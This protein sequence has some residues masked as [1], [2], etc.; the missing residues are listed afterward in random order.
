M[1]TCIPTGLGRIFPQ[2]SQ[3]K[4][5]FRIS[6]KQL[7]RSCP[8]KLEKVITS[9][10]RLLLIYVH[11]LN[12]QWYDVWISFSCVS[13]KPKFSNSVMFIWF[14]KWNRRIR[15]KYGGQ[16][17]TFAITMH[18]LGPWNRKHS[19]FQFFFHWFYKIKFMQLYSR[20][21]QDYMTELRGIIFV[22]R[23][24]E[25]R[26]NNIIGTPVY[27][28]QVV[29]RRRKIWIILIY[30]KYKTTLFIFLFLFHITEFM[31]FI[32]TTLFQWYQVHCIKQLLTR[33]ILWSYKETDACKLHCNS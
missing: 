9:V 29:R 33:T 16:K 20:F 19:R 23:P 31:N 1:D 25:S 24:V 3:S 8:P 32:L 27:I 30:K 22:I 5:Q 17:E 4:W 13:L 18:G 12:A 10:F 26:N 28:I 2:D 14:S 21:L 6:M 7:K 15:E 11:S